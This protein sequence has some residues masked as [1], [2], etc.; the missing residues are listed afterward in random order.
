MASRIDSSKTGDAGG[1]RPED[2]RLT[3]GMADQRPLVYRSDSHHTASGSVSCVPVIAIMR[4]WI[5]PGRR[6]IETR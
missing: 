5:R 3:L 1:P 6:L 2:A 4:G